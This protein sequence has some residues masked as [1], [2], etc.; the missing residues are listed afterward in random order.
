MRKI[1]SYVIRTG[2]LTPGQRR[3]LE[4]YWPAFGLDPDEGP[5]DAKQIF[6]NDNSLVVEVG[7]GMGDSLAEMAAT[8]P[9]TNF[10]G[11]EVHR[12]GVG[13]L[14]RLAHEKSLGNL[15]IYCADVLE[16]FNR[17]IEPASVDRI[18]IFFPDPWPKKRH[19]KRRLINRE[20]AA[21][22]EEKLKPGG[23]VHIATDWADYGNQIRETLSGVGRLKAVSPPRRPRTKYEHRGLRLGHD[24]IE[25]AWRKRDA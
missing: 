17:C 9:E 8:N 22:M 16:V 24:V 3:A 13:H 18:Q 12:P 21:Q 4:E 5:L 1:R 19:H 10:V 23:L 15:R 7:F 6:G 14:L 25:V 2:R 20:F 11:I